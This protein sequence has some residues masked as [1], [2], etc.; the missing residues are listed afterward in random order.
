MN[1]EISGA[2]SAMVGNDAEEVDRSVPH[3]GVGGTV[4]VNTGRAT[5]SRG[6]G[7]GRGRGQG[8]GRGRG[9]GRGQFRRSVYRYE[10]PSK[11]WRK[12]EDVGR[13]VM[14]G[15]FTDDIISSRARSYCSAILNRLT[16]E[17][18][19]NSLENDELGITM[20]F[21][22]DVLQLLCKNLNQHIALNEP[23]RKKL[24]LADMVRWVAVLLM[25]SLA[26][27]TFEKAL[28]EFSL[29][30]CKV[31]SRENMLFISRNVI[32]F[33]PTKRG[34]QS[35]DE[36]AAQRDATQRLDTF[37]RT[38]YEM[39][40]NVCLIANHTTVTL[41]DDLYGTRARDNQVKTLSSRKADKE[42]HS[43][44][45][46]CDAFFRIT[47]GVRFRRRG[48][49]QA[50]NV[51]KLLDVF[52][53]GHGEMSLR[54]IVAS[55][56]R[57]YGSLKL[58]KNFI[59]RGMGGVMIMPNHLL[60]CHPFAA[61]S[62]FNVT[63]HDDEA[64]DYYDIADEDSD[65]S[66]DNEIEEDGVLNEAI[67]TSTFLTTSVSTAFYDRRPTFIIP[68]NPKAGCNIYTAK[69][70]FSIPVYGRVTDRKR[71][72]VTAIAVRERG[73]EK[74]T[75]IIRFLSA[76]PPG[77]TDSIQTWVA[78]PRSNEDDRR[79]LF[80]GKR[81]GC[82]EVQIN[83][84]DE[85]RKRTMVLTKGQRCADWFILRQFRIT[86][87]IA[88]QILLSNSVIM[89]TIGRPTQQS[90]SISKPECL[91][92][93]LKSW[94]SSSRS[95]E[96]MMRGS[97]NEGAVLNALLSRPAVKQVFECGMF[98]LQNEP[99]IACSPD[100]IAW[101]HPVDLCAKFGLIDNGPPFLASV[102]IKT[103][104]ASSSLDIALGNA[105]QDVVY[106]Y[107]GDDEFVK[108]IP[109]GHVGQLL[110][111]ALV[112]DVNFVVYVASSET[113]ILFICI[114]LIPASV[115][116]ICRTTLIDYAKDIVSWA[117]SDDATPPTELDANGKRL[118]SEKIPFWRL[119]NKYVIEHGPMP[120][121]KLFRHGSQTFYSRTKGGVDGSAQYRATLRSSM[122]VFSWEQKLITQTIK[123]VVANAY[124]LWKINRNSRLLESAS[125]YVG[126]DRF[127][128]NINK[129]VSFGN[130]VIDL[131]P[132]LVRYAEKIISHADDDSAEHAEHIMMETAEGKRLHG[133]VATRKRHRV[134]FFNSSDGIQVRLQL[135]PHIQRYTIESKHC[136]LCG[137]GF[138]RRRS[139]FKC[140]TC[141]VHL[142]VRVQ[143]EKRKSC[144][145][146][147]HES[148]RLEVVQSHTEVEKEKAKESAVS[149]NPLQPNS[150]PQ[151]SPRSPPAAL[152]SLRSNA[153]EK[154][155]RPD[156]LPGSSSDSE[157][158]Q[159][160]KS[161]RS[162]TH[163][164]SSSADISAA[165]TA[166]PSK[167]ECASECGR[168]PL[169]DPTNSAHVC[170]TCH[171]PVHAFCVYAP[172]GQLG[173]EEYEG[174]GAG[175]YCKACSLTKT[176]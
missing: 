64:G 136:A 98:A 121:L 31:P 11:G 161:S 16:V 107:V 143:R 57:G 46:L 63:R 123:A 95:T 163:N 66:S 144:W 126:I 140:V 149:D 84:E 86:G 158:I 114:A 167:V 36:W 83:M 91:N 135:Q 101:L 55:A 6:R 80:N 41:D 50:S 37:E 133:L 62:S 42:G 174:Y 152:R 129:N 109:L 21:L 157:D 32:A 89:S 164:D 82:M 24:Q 54:G 14:E 4:P 108:R 94:F 145:A 45:V 104:V 97:G 130:F 172:G 47:L 156:S 132:N 99:W 106:C 10:D 8:R 77:I 115:R 26:D 110:Q 119:V 171:N 159:G 81:E 71:E 151:T 113:G 127:R 69:R 78:V 23:G 147:W 43:A 92:N 122:T 40:R 166:G 173:G 96:T 128:N 118:V 146:K 87:T 49:S 20:L 38:A 59:S 73:T 48:E 39:S 116:Q 19:A 28:E 79:L 169:L 137:T 68:T 9:R 18:K 13:L 61:E 90:H 60:R 67:D 112:L 120:P 25:S 52:T 131:C 30:D 155:K 150:N 162:D 134:A 70:S 154:R 34:K 58:L 74:A 102:E 153:R 141:G 5:V 176:S 165:V 111:Q 27:I 3:G 76:V 124:V 142:C 85:L 56:D 65:G 44:D 139:K 51:E 100:A 160:H 117:H 1:G 170:E 148:K 168:P 105:S 7:R 138:E 15:D 35:E 75:Q 88:G 175:G 17:L 103:S 2:A 33:P 93:L 53:S 125:S 29:R 72:T 22:E 12:H